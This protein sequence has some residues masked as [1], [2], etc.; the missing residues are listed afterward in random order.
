M[1]APTTYHRW[2]ATLR[3]AA[4][5]GQVCAVLG[6][7]FGLG[8]ALP[9][10][11]IAILLAVEIAYNIA[12]PILTRRCP[13]RFEQ[14]LL[15]AQ[16]VA[17]LFALTGLLYF[18]GGPANPFNFLYLVHVVL[19]AVILPSG[20]A[21]VVAVVSSVAFGGLFLDSVPLTM[22]ATQGA[23]AHDA[24]ASHGMGGHSA[25]EMA[26]H[27]KGMWIAFVVAAGFIVYFVTQIRRS[28]HQ[29]TEQLEISNRRA[30]RAERLAALGTLAAGAAHELGSPLASIAIA[31]GELANSDIEEDLR[32]DVQVIRE[33]VDRCRTVLRRM[34]ADLGQALGD[35]PAAIALNALIRGALPRRAG[36]VERS[37][38]GGVASPS[39]SLEGLLESDPRVVVSAAPTRVIL[40]V[41]S[42][43]AALRPLIENAVDASGSVTIVA[44]VEPMADGGAAD[45]LAVEVRDSGPGVPDEILDRIGE[46]FFTTKEAGAGM[47]LG[48]F[49]ARSVAEQLGGTLT[50]ESDPGVG[51]TATMRIPVTYDS[52]ERDDSGEH[53]G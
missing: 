30:E 7:R 32:G 51:T 35:A 10:V 47:G 53:S 37:G 48:V 27:L 14:R 42:V 33:Q 50:F 13:Q 38:L 4:I 23:P 31:A 1:T 11:P 9:L 16:L 21:W 20:W 6:A 43:Q 17:D 40:P 8:L 22:V 24:H 39:A 49:L 25:A 46:P 18:T 41:G 3:W 15:G 52:Q 44:H 29:Q 45:W 26:L 28:L 5:T 34:S 36:V 12:L 19:A 2:L